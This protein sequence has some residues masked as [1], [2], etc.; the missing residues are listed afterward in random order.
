MKSLLVH[1]KNKY[2]NGR[3]EIS[4]DKLDAFCS[5][6]VHR[7]ALRRGGDGVIRDFGKELGAIDKHDLSP[8]PKNAR[9]FK[10]YADGTVNLA[11][12]AQERFG[13]A[14]EIQY[15]NKILSINEYKKA[16]L[17]FDDKENIILPEPPAAQPAPVVTAP[18]TQPEAPAEPQSQEPVVEP[19][20]GSQQ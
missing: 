5:D 11:E 3:V 6:G 7:V 16:G 17:K 2:P 14:E 20:P 18:V 12:E 8:I 4:E 10:L 15:Q 9:V 13:V 19:E 1:Y